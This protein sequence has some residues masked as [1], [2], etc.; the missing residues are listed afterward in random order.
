ML[1]AGV[2]VPD[3]TTTLLEPQPCAAVCVAALRVGVIIFEV[4]FT[5]AAA[6]D[7]QPLLV[8]VAASEY[9]PGLVTDTAA[10]VADPAIPGPDQV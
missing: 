8:L 7:V 6:A 9:T 4:T 2:A 5:V 3:K 10:F 1:P